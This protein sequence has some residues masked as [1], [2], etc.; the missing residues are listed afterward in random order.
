[1]HVPQP[2]QLSVPPH[3]FDRLPHQFPPHPTGV[4]P[5][6]FAV[7]AP[8]HELGLVQLP[9][10]MVPPQRSGIDPQFLPSTEH[11]VGAQPHSPV[12]PAPPQVSGRVQPPQLIAPP[13]PS[14][15]TPQALG[16]RSEQF[17]GVHPHSPGAVPPP[18]VSGPVQPLQSIIEPQP[19]GCIPQ[20]F[21]LMPA[22]VTGVQ[23][24]PLLPGSPSIGASPIA[25]PPPPVVVPPRPPPPP[26]VAA[27]P[28]VPP[29]PKPPVPPKP[30]PPVPP[31]A[32]AM[33]P[34]LDTSADASSVPSP[35]VRPERSCAKHAA[36]SSAAAPTSD[37]RTANRITRFARTSNQLASDYIS[38]KASV[39]RESVAVTRHEHAPRRIVEA[40]RRFRGVQLQRRDLLGLV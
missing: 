38:W 36:A 40:M 8:P 17:I 23:P 3:P 18:Q 10:L 24:S 5:H 28:P 14:R 33:P 4:Q 16:P 7:P 21:W 15:R 22:Q 11:E 31:P 25:S 26:P 2:P 32:P 13:Q 29:V 35:L 30:R 6:T 12:T 34:P 19:S 37:H 27:V 39:T 1:M 20:A 9:Q